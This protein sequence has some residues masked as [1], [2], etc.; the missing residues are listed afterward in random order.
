MCFDTGACI[1][2]IFDIVAE[3]P[4]YRGAKQGMHQGTIYIGVFN[5]LNTVSIP[6]STGFRLS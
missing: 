6:W 4:F 5:S 3:K 1:V 2:L